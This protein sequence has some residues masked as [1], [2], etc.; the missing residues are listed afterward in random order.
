MAFVRTYVS[1][2]HI[3]YIFKVARISEIGTTLAILATN[4]N[5]I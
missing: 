2:K 3:A 4:A 1:E 5:S